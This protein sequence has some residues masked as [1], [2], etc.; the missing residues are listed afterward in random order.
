MDYDC[1][2]GLLLLLINLFNKQTEYDRFNGR[3]FWKP[4]IPLT[5]VEDISPQ[6]KHTA[7]A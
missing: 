1:L 7:E 2:V 4:S 5:W 3:S 6:T